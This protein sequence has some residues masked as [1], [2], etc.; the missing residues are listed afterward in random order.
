MT[1]FYG[2]EDAG[3]KR[4]GAKLRFRVEEI[5]PFDVQTDTGAS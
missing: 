4:V 3:F 5:R 1:K 2:P